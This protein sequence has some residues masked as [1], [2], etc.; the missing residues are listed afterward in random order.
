V[1]R[2]SQHLSERT[3][4]PLPTVA[5]LMKSLSKGGLVTSQ[6]GAGGGYVLGRS[7]SDISVADVIQA[8]EG[9]IALTACAD[10]SDEHCGIES[11]CPVQGKWNKV[12]TAVRAALTEVTLAD[13]VADVAAFGITPPRPSVHAWR[14]SNMAVTRET[15]A[16]V[17]DIEQYKYGF[18]TDIETDKAP[19]GLSEDIIRFISAK[20]NEPEW[21][22]EYRLK[23]YRYWLTL[24]DEEPTWAKLH[25]P[26]IDY[27]ASYY[28][29]APKREKLA[30]LD[31][32]DPKLLETYKKLGIPLL[33]Q[34]MLAGVASIAV[35]DSVSVATTY[36]K[37]LEEMGVIFSPISE[38]VHK[39]PELV[40]KYL[41]SSCPTAI[42]STPRST[43]RSSPTA[44]LFTS[45]RSALPHGAVDL[46]PHQ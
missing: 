35:F 26:K 40:K 20:K 30:S 18:V 28:Y 37:K 8:V 9:P 1:V 31:E 16:A 25:F 46:L 3:G 12:N 44:P 32:V 22:L 17:K 19:K 11:V 42:T 2:S 29:A 13:M 38:A 10:T 41:G 45:Q 43:L 24:A 27:Q 7:P 6:R 36:K 23:A 14:R 33:E 21:M 34:Q 39:H 5:K 15:A 4:I